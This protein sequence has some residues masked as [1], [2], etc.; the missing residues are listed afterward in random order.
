[1]L[2]ELRA[3]PATATTLARALGESTGATSYHLRELEKA[4][5]VED[6]TSQGRGRERWWKRTSPLVLVSSDPAEDA[7]FEAALGQLRSV[8]LARD[9]DAVARYFALAAD[10]PSEW[11]DAAF[12]GGWNVFATPDEMRR[13]SALIIEE[14]DKLRRPI[15][16]RP[17]DAQH[18]YVTF[19]SLLQRLEAVEQQPDERQDDQEQD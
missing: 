14:L 10:M 2:E 19:R 5:L 13:F 8:L 9:E 16:E 3:G 15:E 7:E 4:G 6:D 17:P 1:M 18:V 12:L 11:Q